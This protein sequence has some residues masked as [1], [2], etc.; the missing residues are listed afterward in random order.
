MI[1]KKEIIIIVL[2][3]VNLIIMGTIIFC[4]L[5]INQK[6]NYDIN[7]DNQYSNDLS[8]IQENKFSYKQNYKAN[9]T[10]T[11]EERKK[12]FNFAEVNKPL[13]FTGIVAALITFVLFF[14]FFVEE[15]N[16]EK[17]NSECNKTNNIGSGSCSCGDCACGGSGDNFAGYCLACIIFLLITPFI[18]IYFFTK[19]LGKSISRIIILLILFLFDKLLVYFGLK[20]GIVYEMNIFAYLVIILTIFDAILNITGFTLYIILNYN[21][22]SENI[23]KDSNKNKAPEKQ[24]NDKIYLENKDNNISS[25]DD[26]QSNPEASNHIKNSENDGPES[27]K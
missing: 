2:L 10:T 16:C 4:S 26:I 25:K 6:T 23:G 1:E 27:K 22:F 21:C 18:L 13:F 17:I 15:K 8:A 9:N 12:K 14:S 19:T 24:M 5:K 3:L 7:I 20:Q 11:S